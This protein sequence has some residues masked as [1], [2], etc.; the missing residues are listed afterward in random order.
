[1][2]FR[3]N[4]KTGSNVFVGYE[5][6]HVKVFNFDKKTSKLKFDYEFMAH[7]DPIKNITVN[8]PKGLMVTSCRDGSARVWDTT[9][10]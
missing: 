9:K 1:M 4:S 6:K 3:E 5:N 10:P 2:D 7:M 8:G